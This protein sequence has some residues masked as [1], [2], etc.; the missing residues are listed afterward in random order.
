M[1]TRR[2]SLILVLALAAITVAVPAASTEIAGLARVIDGDTLA[3]NTHR[4][5]I[6]GIDAPETGQSCLDTRGRNYRCGEL[7][8]RTLRHT[9]ANRP[10]RCVVQTRDRYGRSI[11]RCTIAGI[12]IGAE[13]VRFGAALA[14]RRYSRDYVPQET[15]ARAAGAGLWSGSFTPPWIWRRQNR[16][17]LRHPEP[18]RDHGGLRWRPPAISLSPA[19]RHLHEPAR[20]TRSRNFKTAEG[21]VAWLNRDVAAKTLS[22]NPRTNELP[23]SPLWLLRANGREV[24][25]VDRYGL[26]H[27]LWA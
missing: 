2:F 17:T 11:A 26:D 14:Y 23:G 7:S 24:L 8:T 6:H 19:K 1:T 12:D 21:A 16:G 10:I 25:R 18:N 9:I 15:A 3:I 20:R 5:R 22:R 13:Q 4:I 27:G